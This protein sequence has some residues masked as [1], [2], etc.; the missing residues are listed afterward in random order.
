MGKAEK[1]TEREIQLW[2]VKDDQALD[3][4]SGNYVHFENNSIDGY[5]G[6]MRSSRSDDTAD[7]RRS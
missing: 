3:G 2:G 1:T 7:N 5:K 4:Y 6:R